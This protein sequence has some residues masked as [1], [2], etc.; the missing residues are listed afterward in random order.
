[1]RPWIR[2]AL[3]PLQPLVAWAAVHAFAG[4]CGATTFLADGY[5]VRVW[6][7]DDGLPQNMVTSAVQTRDGY[8]WFGTNS[9]LVRFDGERF[10]LFG[11]TDDSELEDRRVTRLY[12][13]ADG[14][15]WVGHG[16]GVVTR[17]HEGRFEPLPLPSGHV[18]DKIIGL[19]GDERGRLWAMHENGM[20]DA[21]DGTARLP[22]LI[23]DDRP[24]VMSFSRGPRGHIWL[25][26]NGTAAR[27]TAEGLVPATLPPPESNNYVLCVASA[28]D[29]TAWII[30]DLRIRKWDGARWTEDR[31]PIPWP[32]GGVACSLELGDGTLAIGTL[33]CGLYLVFPD[34]RP[35]VH[36]DRAD[37][38]PQNWIR[39]LYEDR[40]GNLW[41]GA[42]SAGLVSIHPS[43]FAVLSLPEESRGCSVLSVAA[44]GDGSLWVGTDGAGLYHVSG[45]TWDHYG[46]DKGLANWYIPS[47]AVAPD[48]EVW[49][50][51]FWWGGPYRLEQG[52]FRRPIGIEETSNPVFAL[53]PLGDGEWLVGNRDGLRHWRGGLSTWLARSPD[54]SAPEVCAIARDPAGATWCGFAHGGLARVAEGRVTH[55]READGLAS[56]A[57]TCLLAEPDGTVWVGTADRGVSRFKDGRFATVGPEHGLVDN[58]I[59]AIV[60]DGRGCLWL[61]THHGIQRIDKGALNRC[62]DGSSPVFSS[63]VYDRSDGLPIIEFTSGFQSVAGRTPDGRLWFASGKGLV[64]VDPARIAANPIPPPVVMD[65]VRVDGSA[66]STTEGRVVDRLRPDHERI[67]FRFSGLSFVAPGKVHFRYRLDGID[68]GWID[69]GPRRTAFYSRLPAGTYQF[70]VIACNNDG[71]WNT[72]GASLAFTVAPFFWQ[73]WWFVGAGSLAG[74]TVFALLVRFITRRRMQR[75]MLEFQRQSALERERARIARDIHDD[76]GSS[77]AR[78]AMLSQPATGTLAEPR[79]TAAMLSRIYSTAREVTKAL[80][81]IVWA[82]DPRHDTLDSLVAY[83]GKFAQDFLSAAGIRCRL[84][85][86]VELPNWRITAETRHNLFLA[87]KEALNNVLRHAAATEVRV[88]LRLEPESFVLTIKDN[89]RGIDPQ[90]PA[91]PEPGRLV[92][93]HGLPN[94]QRRLASIGGRCEI[95]S[96]SDMGTSVAF[97]VARQPHG[98]PATLP[99]GVP[100]M[101]PRASAGQ[102]SDFSREN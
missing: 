94:M 96:A 55:F 70:H 16:S 76:V 36:I 7:T 12:E 85:A 69:A 43:A 75:R 71:L 50:S 35:P 41:A 95:S 100:G 67:E 42:G 38:L 32:V 65:V 87:F 72:E 30:C 25:S 86:P 47:V 18:D 64:S 26:E 27:L 61:S 45:G 68:K 15:L 3:S 60:D 9:G 59:C 34:G 48:G 78:I 11:P 13:D 73:T 5:A 62:A 81:E 82:V 19:G 77:L 79:R 83:M 90:R 22:T 24:A 74:L 33:Q 14:T 10:R 40:E 21:L 63:Q 29:G 28:S 93:G 1:M 8:L 54:V 39:F 101:P 4:T 92:S 66:V 98:G 91:T 51:D 80:D 88:S 44:A 2:L 99:P 52:H 56:D 37:G 89:G 23:V 49:A 102:P 17:Y 46:P 53:V 6:Q 58:A 20:V 57:V 84:D 97:I 31:G